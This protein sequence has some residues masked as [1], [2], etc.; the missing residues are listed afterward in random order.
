[1]GGKSITTKTWDGTTND[2]FNNNGADWNP[3]GDPAAGDSV[4]INSGEAYL[5]TGDAGITVASLANSSVLAIADPGVTQAVT[6]NFANSGSTSTTAAGRAAAR[7]R[8]AAR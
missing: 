5:T 7:C 8:S 3:A 1:M 2:W 4:L 6:G